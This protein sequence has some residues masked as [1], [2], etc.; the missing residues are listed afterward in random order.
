MTF[1]VP[2]LLTLLRMGL[3]PLFIIAVVNGDATKALLIFVAAGVT[4]ALE[5]Q[6]DGPDQLRAPRRHRQSERFPQRGR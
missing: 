3:V 5:E 6:P 2:N 1:T 4:D